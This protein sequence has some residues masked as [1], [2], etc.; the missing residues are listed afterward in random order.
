MAD[1]LD[2]STVAQERVNFARGWLR[3]FFDGEGSAFFKTHSRSG[4]RHTNRYLTVGNT[5]IVLMHKCIEY[6]DLLGIE[7]TKFSRTKIA[8]RKDFY[9][10]NI[11]RKE[12]IVKFAELVGFNAPEKQTKLEIMVHWINRDRTYYRMDEIVTLRKEGISFREIARRLNMKEGA[13][14]R[15]SK[16]YQ[17]EEKKWQKN[18]G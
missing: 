14:G 6:L 12:S 8:G 17:L 15:L 5:D 2:I 10:T 1:N 11:V 9:V 13:H 7:Y 16:L 18:I 3:G 4:K